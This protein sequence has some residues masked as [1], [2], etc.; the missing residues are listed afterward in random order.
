V[1]NNDPRRDRSDRHILLLVALATL[2]VSVVWHLPAEMAFMGARLGELLL[3]L[4][5]AMAFTYVLRPMVNALMRVPLLQRSPQGRTSASLLVFLACGVACYVV[6]LVGFKPVAQD[7]RELVPATQAQ[8]QALVMQWKDSVRQA[9]KPYSDFLP[10]KMLDDPKFLPTQG[11]RLAQKSVS[12]LQKQSSHAG[13]VVELL[14]VPVLTFY[15]LSDGP[16]IR[17]ELRLLA[18]PAMRPRLARIADQ[19]DFVLDGYV[20]GQAWMCVIAWILT[21]LMLWALHVPHAAIL[22]LVA[23]LT[24][25]VPVIGPLLGAIPLLFVT[26]FYTGSVQTTSLLLLAF[27]MMHFVESKVLL[28]KIVGHHVDLH[29]VTVILA[30]LLGMEFFGF[31]GVFLAVPIAAVLKILLTEFHLSRASQGTSEVPLPPA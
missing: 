27:F 22:G 30:L 29:P 3:A 18:P 7:L 14:L 15:F 5:L 26:L 9:V 24:R 25:A 10:S 23:G 31:I 2:V 28:P 16:A 11:A 13:F 6:F 20:R 21:T 8:R 19:F 1:T 4:A 17:R 12:W